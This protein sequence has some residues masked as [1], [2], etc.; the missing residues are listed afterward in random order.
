MTEPILGPL[1]ALA[2]LLAALAAVELPRRAAI[3]RRSP[4]TLDVVLATVV[5]LLERVTL[6]RWR[7]SA[8]VDDWLRTPDGRAAWAK[9]ASRANVVIVD[10]S[11]PDSVRVIMFGGGGGGAGPQGLGGAVQGYGHGYARVIFMGTE[12]A[13]HGR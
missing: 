11:R 4:D 12:E 10:R 8:L 13:P 7:R 5:V 3:P 1:M 6:P 9:F 2:I